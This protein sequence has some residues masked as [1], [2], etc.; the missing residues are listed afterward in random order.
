MST[1]GYTYTRGYKTTADPSWVDALFENGNDVTDCISWSDD[2]D[3]IAA[4]AI[5]YTV[6]A[7]TYC[8]LVLINVTDSIQVG[9]ATLAEEATSITKAGDYIY[10]GTAASGIYRLEIPDC[11]AEGGDVTP[12]GWAAYYD[13]GGGEILS[14]TVDDLHGWTVT[15]GDDFLAVA[16]TGGATV[17]NITD[18]THY[19][20]DGDYMDAHLVTGCQPTT[21]QH[22]LYWTTGNLISVQYSPETVAA[23]DWLCDALVLGRIADPFDD[24]E[25]Y[26]WIIDDDGGTSDDEEADDKLTLEIE[27]DIDGTERKC[28][29]WRAGL[30]TGDY[31]FQVK[32]S[33]PAWPGALGGIGHACGARLSVHSTFSGNTLNLERS[34]INAA[35]ADEHKLCIDGTAITGYTQNTFWLRIY[36]E[37]DPHAATQTTYAQYKTNDG[38]AW[39]DLWNDGGAI[40]YQDPAQVRLEVFSDVG[41]WSQQ[42]EFLDLVTG[43]AAYTALEM[44][45]T[46]KSNDEYSC[47]TAIPNTSSN[48]S[49]TLL[50]GA[51]SGV[52]GADTNEDSANPGT[53]EYLG[54]GGGWYNATGGGVGVYGVLQG[55]DDNVVAVAASPAAKL[56][57]GLGGAGAFA[58]STSDGITVV[59]LSDNTQWFALN[60]SSNQPLVDNDQQSLFY[61]APTASL[62]LH[63]AGSYVYGA[64]AGGGWVEPDDVAPA[65]VDLELRAINEDETLLGWNMPSEAD[66]TYSK[67][68]RAKNGGAYSTLQDDGTWGAGSDYEFDDD[69]AFAD[70]LSFYDV[71]IAADGRYTYRIRQYDEAANVSD[72]STADA[73]IDE[74]VMVNV[75][76]SDYDGGST[77]STANRGVIVECVGNSGDDS[78]NVVHGVEDIQIREQGQNWADQPTQGYESGKEYDFTLSSGNGSKTVEVRG[79][80]QGGKYGSAKSDSITLTGQSAAATTPDS[81]NFILAHSFAGDDATATDSNGDSDYPPANVQDNRIGLAWRSDDTAESYIRFNFGAGQTVKYIAIL[82]HNFDEFDAAYQGGDTWELKIGTAAGAG[83]PWTETEIKALAGDDMIIVD[84]NDC[85]GTQYVRLSM[86]SDSAGAP[87]YFEVGRIVVVCDD[88]GFIQ[89]TYNFNNQFAWGVKEYGNLVATP[90]ARY[91]ANP[92]KVRTAEITCS[93]YERGERAPFID[94]FDAVGQEEPVL[95]ILKPE[96][97]PVKND[98]LHTA[99][100][101][102]TANSTRGNNMCLY[103]Y[104]ADDAQAWQMQSTDYGSAMIR[105]EEA[106]E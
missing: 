16:T 63:G 21:G 22:R 24:E 36:L 15:G 12:G 9:Y 106:V 60:E 73:L 6:S 105:V 5:A 98:T 13:S 80:S 41:G 85:T 103:G 33:I 27:T 42:A 1:N 77:S 97:L 11:Q 7:S 39:I 88:S 47:L 37:S 87:D 29:A 74:P 66:W 82:G 18:G 32:I 62:V 51:S 55:T 64:A 3:I 31:D 49:T 48:D 102:D 38:D 61:I 14:D 26:G 75:S 92:R 68:A 19:D 56:N 71:S 54:S 8:C 10:I 65:D 84:M 101:A 58:A 94:A 50:A 34:F 44:D 4:Y 91:M 89:P 25:T 43:Y 104:F 45:G 28:Y 53:D 35:G 46:N 86:E 99:V 20:G 52:T 78:T 40:G 72:G 17:I 93:L 95:L 69:D 90:S 70:T 96:I 83:G 81:E 76:L 30:A 100:W 67:L 23:D 79:W 2:S 57:F 59:D